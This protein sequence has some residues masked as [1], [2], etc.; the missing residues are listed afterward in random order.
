MV[1]Q[2]NILNNC[3]ELSGGYAPRT[4]HQGH[5]GLC[6]WTPLGDFLSP[7]PLCP[8]SPNPGYTTGPVMHA[9]GLLVSAVRTGD[10]DQQQRRRRSTGYCSTA[11]SSKCEQCPVDS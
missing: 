6:P 4:T 1:W 11:L 8:P 7:D 9:A 3:Y 10:V 2:P 5:Q